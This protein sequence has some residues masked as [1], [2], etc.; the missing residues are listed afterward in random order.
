MKYFNTTKKNMTL[1]QKFNYIK[2][3]FTYFTLNSWNGLTSIANNVK[4][5]KLG[6]TPKQIDKM[7]NIFADE[8]L[9]DEFYESMNY[10]LYSFE[11]RN[12][13]YRVGFNGRSGGYLVI[14]PNN[15]NGSIINGDID[16]AD[17]Y[18]ELVKNFVEYYGWDYRD[19]QAESKQ[20]IEDLFDIVV[21]FDDLCDEKSTKNYREI[22]IT[23]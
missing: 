11:H 16:N 17:T 19:A 4:V 8:G 2:N 7:L 12:P 1:T 13:A 5:H 9:N 15:N 14:T 23:P 10:I 21:K 20:E 18:K 3:H 6:L 22:K